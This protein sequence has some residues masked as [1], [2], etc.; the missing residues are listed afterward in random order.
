MSALPTSYPHPA[1]HA[2][3]YFVFLEWPEHVSTP[4]AYQIRHGDYVEIC[5]ITGQRPSTPRWDNRITQYLSNFQITAHDLSDHPT[6]VPNMSVMVTR[7]LETIR[8]TWFAPAGTENFERVE[9]YWIYPKRCAP[10]RLSRRE[11]EAVD[12]ET[13]LIGRPRLRLLSYDRQAML[14]DGPLS[15]FEPAHAYRFKPVPPFP[16]ETPAPPPRGRA[17]RIR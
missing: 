4:E 9:Q 13:Q 15:R 5:V 12:Y 17:I 8:D 1:G 16:G 11:H 3:S 10:K 6:L 7:V 14:Y 2:L